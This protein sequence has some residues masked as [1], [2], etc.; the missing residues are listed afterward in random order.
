MYTKFYRGIFSQKPHPK[1]AETTER[2]FIVP[3]EYIEYGFGYIIRRSA[4]TPYSIFLRGTIGF[5]RRGQRV[6]D[7]RKRDLASMPFPEIG[8]IDFKDPNDNRSPTRGTRIIMNLSKVRG[9]A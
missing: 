6:W 7:G 1:A 9:Q 5:R 4:H 3:L 2:A 8:E